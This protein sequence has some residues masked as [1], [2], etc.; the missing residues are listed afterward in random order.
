MSCMYRTE[1]ETELSDCFTKQ[2]LEEDGRNNRAF[3]QCSI[4]IS[5]SHLGSRWSV[6]PETSQAHRALPGADLCSYQLHLWY[7]TTK[8]GVQVLLEG[9]TRYIKM[10]VWQTYIYIY[11]IPQKQNSKRK[12]NSELGQLNYLTVFSEQ[13]LDA[14][15]SPVNLYPRC[16]SAD[17]SKSSISQV[18]TA[19]SMGTAC[20]ESSLCLIWN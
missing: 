6:L 19:P 2:Q 9:I 14:S 1:G 12:L 15:T 18:L 3:M 13:C 16:M 10:T 11:I 4:C 20:T 5:P 8:W 7:S 17:Q